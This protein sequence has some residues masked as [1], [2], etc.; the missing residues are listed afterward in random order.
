MKGSFY[1]D[2]K[3]FAIDTPIVPRHWSN[4]LFNEHYMLETNEMLQGKSKTFLNYAVREYAGS[5]R[6]FYI[7]NKVT[8][9]VICPLYAPLNTLP[10]TYRSEYML[11]A[12]RVI[13][14]FAGLECTI[15]AFVPVE[16]IKELWTVKIKNNTEKRTELSLF[17]AF[18]LEDLSWMGSHAEYDEELKCICKHSYPPHAFYDDKAKLDKTLQYVYFYATEEAAAF[19]TNKYRFYGSENDTL[20]PAEISEG[21]LKNTRTQGMESIIAALQHD[22]ALDPGE[23]YSVGFVLGMTASKAQI[24]NEINTDIAAEREKVE[25]LWEKRCSRCRFETGNKELDALANYWLKK[26]TSYLASTNRFGP[27]SPVRNELQDAMGYAFSEPAGAYEIMK[28]VLSRQ[29]KNGYIKQWN[30]HDGAQASGLALLRHSD[31]PIWIIICF[32]ETVTYIIGDNSLYEER[33]GYSDCD[34]TDTVLEHMRRAAYFMSDKNELGAHG[35]CLM[36]DGD[37]T[38]PMNAPGRF[39]R[40]ES[41]WNSMALVYAI[42]EL[43]KLSYD[44][45]LK[46]RADML[47]E[48]IN[49]YAWD[50]SWYLAA[51]DDNGRSVGTHADEEG[52]IFLNTQTWAVISGVARGERLA[53]VKKSIESLKAVCGYR[54][55]EPAFSEWNE[56]WGK[57]SVKQMGALENGAVYCHG[58]MFKALGDVVSGDYA[59]ALD[60]ICA[61][62]PTNPCNPDNMQLPLFVPNYYFGL[63]NENFGRSSCEYNTG[64]AAWILALLS[65]MGMRKAQTQNGE[66]EEK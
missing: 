7:K 5:Q 57:I 52:K 4:R 11:G 32:I 24:K 59:A 34:D 16:G 23:E 38:D 60:A 18:S 50:G 47:E 29:K 33:V 64:T 53:E 20:L 62:L 37:W 42:K 45:E 66:D 48:S 19:E 65:R 27:S 54:L 17:S 35:L 1:E 25:Q 6:H 28:R 61:T 55:L 2:G 63:E 13:S 36:R 22:L 10:D 43:L 3:I 9:E 40:G 8:G 39:G 51:I 26:Q 44:E 15:E 56:K 46:R 30:L 58:T 41:V 14:S 49:K 21:R 12:H 31:A